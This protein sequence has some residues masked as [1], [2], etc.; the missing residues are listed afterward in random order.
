M[1][2]TSERQT[3]KQKHSAEGDEFSETDSSGVLNAVAECVTTGSD[4]RHARTKEGASNASPFVPETQPMEMPIHEAAQRSAV[5]PQPSQIRSAE[6]TS[7]ALLTDTWSNPNQS[8]EKILEITRQ[9]RAN[10]DTLHSMSFQQVFETHEQLLKSCSELVNA[11]NDGSNN[12]ERV[13]SDKLM[14]E[15]AKRQQGQKTLIMEVIKEC[16]NFILKSESASMRAEDRCRKNSEDINRTLYLFCRATTYM[17]CCYSP[18]LH[19]ALAT[20]TNATL[21]GHRQFV[22][23]LWPPQPDK[24]SYVCPT[25]CNKAKEGDV[26]TSTTSAPTHI[27]KRTNVGTL[28]WVPFHSQK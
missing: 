12:I 15:F 13:S 3:K 22:T 27:A 26:Y 9:L 6:W 24:I 1:F 14:Q 23:G 17:C 5:Q 16:I 11:V 21:D 20:M 8:V 25:C 2:P 4:K 19:S 7:P 28:N 18:D 10:K